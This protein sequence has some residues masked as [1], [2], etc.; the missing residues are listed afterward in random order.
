MIVMLAV[1]TDAPPRLS[2]GSLAVRLCGMPALVVSG[3]RQF[4]ETTLV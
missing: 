2:S 4:G 3:P 1:E